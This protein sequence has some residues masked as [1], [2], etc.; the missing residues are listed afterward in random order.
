MLDSLGIGSPLEDIGKDGDGKVMD[1]QV[2]TIGTSVVLQNASPPFFIDAPSAQIDSVLV[3]AYDVFA[4]QSALAG[5]HTESL[6]DAETMVRRRTQ[7]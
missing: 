2:V 6:R 5:S 1:L 7:A 4:V 3:S